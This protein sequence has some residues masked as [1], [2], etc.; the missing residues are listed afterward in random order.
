MTNVNVKID[1]KT[2][3]ILTFCLDDFMIE[4]QSVKF[5][6]SHGF[7]FNRNFKHGIG[8]HKG[9]D[10]VLAMLNLFSRITE[11]CLLKVGQKPTLFEGSGNLHYFSAYFW[12]IKGIKRLKNPKIPMI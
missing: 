1:N 6:S 5:L 3:N 2:F 4:S 9:N 11:I 7:D 12:L 8:Y 10:K